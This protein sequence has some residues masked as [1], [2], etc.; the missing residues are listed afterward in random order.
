MRS[1]WRRR[2]STSAPRGGRSKTLDARSGDGA[3]L[4]KRRAA[5]ESR[6]D[7]I[8][9]PER[10]EEHSIIATPTLIK[11][12]PPPAIRLIGEHDASR[13]ETRP[14]RPTPALPPARFQT[15]AANL[16]RRSAG[17]SRRNDIHGRTTG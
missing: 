12:D 5:A 1:E 14:R 9:S 6:P 13:A 7:V 10:A 4:Q 11:A 2:R 8:A 16:A 3:E 17:V 15:F